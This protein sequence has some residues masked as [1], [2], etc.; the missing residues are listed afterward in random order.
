M[1]LQS[2]PPPSIS[3][4]QMNLLRIVSSLA[5][6]D[7]SLAKEEMDIMLNQFSGIFSDDAPQQQQLRQ[8]LQEYLMQN[9]PLSE[10]VPKLQTEDEKK[11]VLRLGYAVIACSARSPEESNINDDEATAYQELVSLLGLPSDTVQQIET[12]V[13]AGA[14]EDLVETLTRHLEEYAQG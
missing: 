14:D 10:S 4:R 3:P 5:W 2:P 7:G 6:S 12:A 9:I 13:Q 11:L 1:A 8:E